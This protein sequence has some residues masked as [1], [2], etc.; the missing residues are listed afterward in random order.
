M[1]TVTRTFS[2]DL[3]S[4]YIPESIIELCHF[5]D[6]T[7]DTDER[8]GIYLEAW[9]CNLSLKSFN[10]G[11]IP[12]FD[13]SESESEKMAMFTATENKS[14][15]VGLR[16][17]GR[18]NNTGGWQEKA[19]IILVNRGR[20]DYFDLLQPY[21]A[22]NSVRILEKNDALG[23]Q[24]IDY[25]NGLLTV[26]DSIGIELGITITISK[27]NN[28]D[29]FNA[30]LAA[31]ESLLQN[32]LINVLGVGSHTFDFTNSLIK[33]GIGTKEEDA[34]FAFHCSN[35]GLGICGFDFSDNRVVLGSNGG[36]AIELCTNVGGTPGVDNLV[37]ATAVLRIQNNNIICPILPTS[38]AGL[39]VGA[40]YRNGNTIA[41]V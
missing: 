36:R 20:K 31:M 3:T 1:D 13:G 11:V 32:R 33:A 28:M 25:G 22:K 17:L 5:R 37:N 39:P 38:S 16:I 12:N 18:K 14:Q 4:S 40:L 34:I 41:V 26:N 23:I 9:M 30:R 21:L 19:E 29:I 27:K 6:M 8:V 10:L 7:F 2:I 24:L 35:R 15:K